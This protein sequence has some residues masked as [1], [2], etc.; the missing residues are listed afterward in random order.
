FN[1]QLINTSTRNPPHPSPYHIALNNKVD[2]AAK[3]AGQDGQRLGIKWTIKDARKEIENRIKEEWNQEYKEKIT[4]KGRSY[5]VIYP[6]LIK[7]TW[8]HKKNINMNTSQ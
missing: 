6:D 3:K 1:Q 5:G 8:F 4:T 2:E 7:H